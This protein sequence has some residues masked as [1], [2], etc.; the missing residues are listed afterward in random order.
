L[1][2]IITQFL[3]A[4]HYSLRLMNAEK[5][6]LW[7]EYSDFATWLQFQMKNAVYQFLMNFSTESN[8]K[9]PQ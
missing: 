3:P 6:L 5:I 4:V 8:A 9:C 1:F 7:Y 2:Q